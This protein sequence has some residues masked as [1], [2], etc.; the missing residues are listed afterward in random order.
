MTLFSREYG[1]VEELH[2]VEEIE[3]LECEYVCE[4]VPFCVETI[5]ISYGKYRGYLYLSKSPDLP[6]G[7]GNATGCRQCHR[8]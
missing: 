3:Y 5:C 6:T 8:L 2:I 4:I 7:V 1:F